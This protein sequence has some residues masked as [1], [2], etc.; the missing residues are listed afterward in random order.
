MLVRG[1]ANIYPELVEPLVLQRFP[2][3]ADVAMIG[4]PDALARRNA[5]NTSSLLIAESHVARVADPA[6]GAFAV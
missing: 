3:V 1:Q 2:E 5:R 6:G 4:L